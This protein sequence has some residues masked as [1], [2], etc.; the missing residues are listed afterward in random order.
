MTICKGSLAVIKGINKFDLYS[1]IGEAMC[2]S[3]A[4]VTNHDDSI[5]WHKRIGQTSEKSLQYLTKT[6]LM[7]VKFI[8]LISVITV[9]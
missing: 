7:V 3:A 4:L 9:F 1:F 5:S 6:Y 2:E 8:H